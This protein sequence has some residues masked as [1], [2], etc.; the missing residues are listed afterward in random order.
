MKKYTKWIVGAFCAVALATSAY[1]AEPVEAWTV[2]LGGGGSTMTDGATPTVFGLDLSVGRT[3]KLLLPV[4]GGIRQSVSYGDGTTLLSTRG[5]MDF[6]LFTVAKTV[7]V[8]A[9]GNVGISYGNTTPSWEIAPEA[10]LRLWLK[11]SVAILAR[12]EAPFNLDGWAFKDTVRYFVG[13]Q[14]K[15]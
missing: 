8:F 4:E 13:F 14:V 10:G 1:A 7:D 6:T 15:F 12:A 9:G 11:D 5:Y 2:S 3:G